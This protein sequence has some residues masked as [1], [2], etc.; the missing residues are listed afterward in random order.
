MESLNAIELMVAI[1]RDSKCETLCA[2][3]FL[4]NVNCD[5]LQF[6][7]TDF[8]VEMFA[9]AIEMLKFKN[10]ALRK[11]QAQWTPHDMICNV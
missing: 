5:A 11:W 2:A 6:V 8:F 10:F 4:S 7:Q 9:A 1:Y 3:Y